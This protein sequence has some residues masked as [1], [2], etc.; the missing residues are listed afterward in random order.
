MNRIV[1]GL[2]GL[3]ISCAFA[4]AA[5]ADGMKRSTAASE[6]EVSGPH[7]WSGIYFGGSLGWAWGESDWT[8]L[9]G[10]RT[11]PSFDG[12]I[13]GGHVGAQHQ[14]GNVVVGVEASLSGGGPIDGSA[15]CPNPSFRCHVNDVDRIFTI[16]PRVGWAAD[17]WMAY[18][19]GG[20]ANAKIVTDTPFV[21][22]GVAFDSTSSHHR[23]WF[24]GA[25]VEFI[26]ARNL[27]L[28]VEYQHIDLE[29]LRHDGPGVDAR[30]LDAD[31]D[32]VRARL[33]FLFGRAP[34]EAA[35]LK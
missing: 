10:N 21:A 26:L 16:G 24:V 5:G 32:L 6:V 15:S 13:A 18:G 9:N 28:G 12:V 19:T 31:L 30:D 8:F 33:S 20:Y 1:A 11:S 25:G 2:L 35:P 17:R 34:R 29:T 14:W 7:N 22:T 27:V 23:G 3:I 4:A